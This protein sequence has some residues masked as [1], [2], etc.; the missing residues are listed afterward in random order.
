V[1]IRL[2]TLDDEPGIRPRFHNF[3]ADAPP[4]LP[5]PDDRLERFAEAKR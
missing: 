1:S 4:W 2:G 5:V 3:V